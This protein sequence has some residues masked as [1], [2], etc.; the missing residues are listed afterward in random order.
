L[1][2]S[3][4]AASRRTPESQGFHFEL[5]AVAHAAS[6]FCYPKNSEEL[7]LF[8]RKRTIVVYSAAVW[9]IMLP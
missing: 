8:G 4:A 9:L 2:G 6:D 1:P 5:F 3:K 7:F